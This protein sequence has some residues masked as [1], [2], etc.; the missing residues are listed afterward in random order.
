MLLQFKENWRNWRSVT[1]LQQLRWF[2]NLM[3][4]KKQNH[5]EKLSKFQEISDVIGISADNYWWYNNLLALWNNVKESEKDLRSHEARVKVIIARLDNLTSIHKSKLASGIHWQNTLLASLW[6]LVQ[7][8]QKL[9]DAHNLKVKIK[10]AVD[11][12]LDLRLAQVSLTPA[13]LLA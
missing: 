3:Q 6:E 12:S 13:L 2:P 7:L 10:G 8:T 5:L 1:Y 11:P 9:K 4:R